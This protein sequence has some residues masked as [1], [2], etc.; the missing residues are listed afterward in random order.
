LRCRLRKKSS[1][2]RIQSTYP[3]SPLSVTEKFYLRHPF[4]LSEGSAATS[5]SSEDELSSTSV[6][7]SRPVKTAGTRYHIPISSQAPNVVKPKPEYSPRASGGRTGKHRTRMH[8]P[9]SLSERLSLLTTDLA[10]QNGSIREHSVVCG[11]CGSS[12]ALDGRH[13]YY[14]SHIFNPAV[15]RHRSLCRSGK[16]SPV[17]CHTQVCR[18]FLQKESQGKI[19]R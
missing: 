14:C 13:K 3:A 11:L 16:R 2:R 4:P 10:I 12:V 18:N 5:A 15:T 9:V 17:T 6:F 19:F 1:S 8:A 7:T